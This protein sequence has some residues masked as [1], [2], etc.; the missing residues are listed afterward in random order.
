MEKLLSSVRTLYSVQDVFLFHEK[1]M[2]VLIDVLI[3]T[4]ID[5]QN[6]TNN[7]NTEQMVE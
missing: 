3:R 5:S 6:C 7:D 2:K 4:L 1:D